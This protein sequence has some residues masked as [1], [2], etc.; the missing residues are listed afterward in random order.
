MLFFLPLVGIVLAG[1][2]FI[3]YYLFQN[4][5]FLVVS[6][7]LFIILTGFLHLE[8][9]IDVADAIYAK[10]GGKDAYRVIKEPTVGAIGVLWGVAV[11]I[12]K[13]VGYSYLLYYERYL[14]IILIA[15]FSRAILLFLIYFYHFKSK[16]LT[17]LKESLSKFSLLFWGV[18][19][20]KFL[21]LLAVGFLVSWWLGKMLGFKN[22]DVLG[23]TLE[24]VEVMGFLVVGAMIGL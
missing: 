12:L 18:L 5:L 16:F 3:P 15:M 11:F 2:S 14:D 13:I 24:M 21:P 6:A 22:G 23:A 1:I 9:V 19:G 7:V 10:M 20:V 17:T 8:A 4:T